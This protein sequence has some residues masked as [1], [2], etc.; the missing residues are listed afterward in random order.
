MTM[1]YETA[2]RAIEIYEE[3]RGSGLL[4]KAA[5]SEAVTSLKR[6]AEGDLASKKKH[7]LAG[8]PFHPFGATYL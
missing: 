4:W 3:G 6:E 5:V 8:L 7:P 2:K 1:K